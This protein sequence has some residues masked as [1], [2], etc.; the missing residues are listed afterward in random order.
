MPHFWLGKAQNAWIA[1]K[2][3][4]RLQSCGPGALWRYPAFGRISS[5]AA[6]PSWHDAG[7][8]EARRRCKAFPPGFTGMP[9]CVT[10]CGTRTACPGQPEST[11]TAA[12]LLAG[13]L[14]IVLGMPR[15]TRKYTHCCR[16]APIPQQGTSSQLG[17]RCCVDGVPTHR[18]QDAVP[19][20]CPKVD[21]FTPDSGI[22]IRPRSAI[23]P[24]CFRS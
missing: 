21:A 20:L 24:L 6:S 14:G 13:A 2:S 23:L 8:A 3:H 4:N 10:S 22:S 9:R 1:S 15:S 11:L 17:A 19:T 7:T 18:R 5:T 12:W 16:T